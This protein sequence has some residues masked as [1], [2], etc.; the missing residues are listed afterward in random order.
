MIKRE[1]HPEKTIVHEAGHAVG[2]LVNG[3]GVALV[4]VDHDVYG[5][6]GL[7]TADFTN[8]SADYGIVI[9]DMMGPMAAGDPPPSWPPD[10]DAIEKDERNLAILVEY[11]ELD[12]TAYKFAIAIAAH[13]LDDPEVKAAHALLCQALHRVPVI[14]GE[15]LR[16]LLGPHLAR[17]QPEEAANAAA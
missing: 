12:E 17:L 8:S 3:H 11:L 9:A 16:E 10:P 15:Q 4:R 6:L 7:C 14:T 2:L 13:L 5:E 1:D